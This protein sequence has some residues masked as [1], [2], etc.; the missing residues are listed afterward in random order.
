M[1]GFEGVK[2]A[3]RQGMK[4]YVWLAI[5]SSQSGQRAMYYLVCR[6]GGE[7]IGG[8]IEDIGVCVCECTRFLLTTP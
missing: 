3:R 6:R 1:I 4:W 7:R 8:T 2:K 5:S